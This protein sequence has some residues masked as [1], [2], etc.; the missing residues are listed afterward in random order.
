MQK[1]KA[2]PKDLPGHQQRCVEW[3]S[4]PS[5]T[6]S[7]YQSGK[8][9]YDHAA[10]AVEGLLGMAATGLHSTDTLE[11]NEVEGGVDKDDDEYGW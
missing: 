1:D 4:C 8:E 10:N 7:P 9:D 11:G 5:P 6:P 3:I 2:I